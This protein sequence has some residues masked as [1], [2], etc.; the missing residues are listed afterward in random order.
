M[1]IQITYRPNEHR[2]GLFFIRAC[3]TD[4]R[5]KK[6]IPYSYHFIRYIKIKYI[7]RL[8]FAKKKFFFI[9]RF[10]GWIRGTGMGGPPLATLFNF[11]SKIAF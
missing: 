6:S 10:I 11:F 5:G 7:Q 3:F 2:H 8:Q 4:N 9:K 1:H